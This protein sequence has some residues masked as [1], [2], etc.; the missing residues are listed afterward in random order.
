[1]YYFCIVY[2]SVLSILNLVID[3][4]ERFEEHLANSLNRINFIYR[5]E[6]I[7]TECIK[8]SEGI[9][10][11]GESFGPFEKGKR[12]KLKLFSAIPFIENDVLKV[13]QEEKCDNID[14]QRYAIG[15]R[16]DQQ[17][18]KRENNLFLN[19][20]KEFKRFMEH[21]IKKS[22]KPNID[23]DRY[24][25]YTSNII[26]GRLLKILKLAKAELSLDDELRLTNSEKLLYEYLY[27]LI[28]TW[29]QFFL[30]IK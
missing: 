23:L 17:L 9:S 11:L 29:R 25:S 1:L 16:D 19:K 22:Y 20:L 26:D 30:S 14:V 13:E 27:N 2:I 4:L 6:N 18:I 15:E 5:N 7:I 8:S 24:N 12:Y 21:D 28:K 10:I 3:F